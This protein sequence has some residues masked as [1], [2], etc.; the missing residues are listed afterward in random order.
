MS[1]AFLS[2]YFFSPIVYEFLFF[3]CLFFFLKEAFLVS[4]LFC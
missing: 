4:D 1:F 3:V 2:F